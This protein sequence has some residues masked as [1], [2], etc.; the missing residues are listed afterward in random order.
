MVLVNNL[1]VI[2]IVALVALIVFSPDRSD[3]SLKSPIKV[4]KIDDE[5]E[6]FLRK[7]KTTIGNDYD[8]YRGHIYRV[9]TYALHFLGGDESYKSVVGIALVYHDIGLWTDEKL[10]YIEPSCKKVN[11]FFYLILTY[12]RN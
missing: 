3:V 6:R 10:G 9:M 7:Y 2:S 8:G 12:Y 1:I 4:I 11:I 5:V